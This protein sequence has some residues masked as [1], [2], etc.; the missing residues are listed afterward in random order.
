MDRE[1]SSSFVIVEDQ[2]SEN[3]EIEENPLEVEAASI[4]ASST[5]S[6]ASRSAIWTHFSKGQDAN[7][8]FGKCKHCR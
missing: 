6:V 2:E 4:G 5:H 8:T 7:G 3:E 1:D